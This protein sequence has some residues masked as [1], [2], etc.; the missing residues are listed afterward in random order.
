MNLIDIL[1]LCRSMIS[2]Q[3]SLARSTAYL[4]NKGYEMRQK[5]MPIKL[6]RNYSK[7]FRQ[8]KVASYNFIFHLQNDPG[9]D[10][11]VVMPFPCTSYGIALFSRYYSQEVFPKFKFEVVELVKT[12]N[13]FS[14]YININ[15]SCR[16]LQGLSTKTHLWNTLL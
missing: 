6:W 7:Y 13:I 10:L 14:R 1:T 2:F 15:S 5:S 8:Q 11:Y 9:H 16:V 4:W 3:Y 12:W